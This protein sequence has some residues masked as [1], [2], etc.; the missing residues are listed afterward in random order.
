MNAADVRKLTEQAKD[1][2]AAKEEEAQMAIEAEWLANGLA[3]V[4]QCIQNAAQAGKSYCRH[5]CDTYPDF[6]VKYFENLGFEVQVFNMGRECGEFDLQ[7]M[8]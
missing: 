2:Q 8:W 3:K 4:E 6:V 7:I 1:N 5:A